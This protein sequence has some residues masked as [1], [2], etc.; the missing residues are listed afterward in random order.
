MA[1]RSA[2]RSVADSCS[3]HTVDAVA[4][5]GHLTVAGRIVPEVL[6][7]RTT[8]AV[9]G[10]VRK[11]PLAV[12]PAIEGVLVKSRE[13]CSTCAVEQKRAVRVNGSNAGLKTQSEA[14]GTAGRTGGGAARVLG[15]SEGGHEGMHPVRRAP[16]H[17]DDNAIA[18]EVAVAAIEIEAVPAECPGVFIEQPLERWSSRDLIT[19]VF[20]LVRW[21]RLATS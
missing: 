21:T 17:T 10:V 9:I 6:E 14:G 15:M 4:L 3:R 1:V 8:A 20:R 16:Q 2:R 18:L 19:G 12:S 11:M 13:R 7:G 5:Y